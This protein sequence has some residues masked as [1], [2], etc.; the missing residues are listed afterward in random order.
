MPHAADKARA[1]RRIARE[2]AHCPLCKKGG[3]GKPVPGEGHSSAR[4]VFV[5]EAPGRE[6]EKTGRP[7][8]G[9]S[10]KFLRQAIK[11]IGLDEQEVFITSPVHYRPL[12][13]TPSKEAVLHG[14][15]HLLKQIAVIDPE[16]IVLL[17]NTARLA[18]FERDAG[19]IRRRGNLVEKDGRIHLITVHP[20]YAMRFPRGKARFTRDF[21]GLKK[22]LRQ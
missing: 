18:I 21:A 2:I 14:R 15:K 3:A 7:F 19:V 17:G 13:G 22:L 1:L 9:R 5:G 6:E 4:I 8:I 16:V 12:R 10:G 20:A 11:R